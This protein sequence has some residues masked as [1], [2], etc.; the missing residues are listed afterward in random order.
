M[1]TTPQSLLGKR[2][3]EVAQDLLRTN[4]GQPT[5]AVPPLQ[6][7]SPKGGKAPAQ[8]VQP[9]A[10]SATWNVPPTS[11]QGAKASPAILTFIG[12][13]LV[14]VAIWSLLGL[15][16]RNVA[17]TITTGATRIAQTSQGLPTASVR[18]PYARPTRVPPSSDNAGGGGGIPLI[19]GTVATITPDSNP[20]TQTATVTPTF[21][22]VGPVTPEGCVL[23]TW[24]DGSQSCNDGRPISEAQSQPGFCKVVDFTGEGDFACASGAHAGIIIPTDVPAAPTNTPWPSA[25]TGRIVYSAKDG[26]N[27]NTCIYL[28]WTDGTHQPATICSDPGQK[29]DDANVQ[30]IV[31]YVEDGRLSPM[32]GNTPHG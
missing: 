16:N 22:S 6:V 4:A 24:A 19:S 14:A 5:I 8:M 32:H 7:E 27:N 10:V 13:V 17:S 28:T 23:T 29:Y 3:A 21:A 15:G 18:T 26:P 2:A 31:R 1:E 11:P 9:A 20:I 25:P 12:V 30:A